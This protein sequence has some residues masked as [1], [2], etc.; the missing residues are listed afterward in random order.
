M[1]KAQ[2]LIASLLYG[3]FC[4]QQAQADINGGGSTFTR[5]LYQTSGVLTAG[6]A[7]YIG[8]DQ[9]RDKVAFLQNNY[10]VLVPGAAP[11][12]VH[13]VASESRLSAVELSNY[14]LAHQAQFGK[15]I[16]VPSA[17]TSVAIPFNK[18]GSHELDLSIDTL[19]GVFS[20]RLSR[21]ELI[22]G[23]ARSGP[24][25]VVYPKGSSGFTELFTR[26][27]NAKCNETGTFAVTTYF[28]SSYS[29]GLPAGAL[30][31]NSGD[32]IMTAVN[33]WDGAITF[34]SPA[35]A[36]PTLAG[37]DDGN[38]VARITGVSP[39]PAN[40]VNAINSVALPP[41]AERSNPDKWVP[42]FGRNWE[43]GVLP[44]PQ[45]GYPILG[46]TNLIFSQCYADATQSNQVRD[47]LAR[48][49]GALEARNNDQAIRA[50]GMLPLH[51]S[52]KVAVRSSFL[53]ATNALSIGN[54]NV[55]NGIGRP[56]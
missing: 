1:P 31:A 47:F 56:L 38:K 53:S 21:W 24:I 44:Y 35:L 5:P 18:P 15:L 10:S 13:W 22:Q 48:H 25:T 14:A 33:V 7:P 30:A 16:Q 20:G 19:C 29:G 36:A 34:M 51:P 50:Q 12:T 4:V 32:A 52:W 54:P 39:A 55:C 3:A 49:Y 27:L 37:L 8:A 42:V 41:I 46:Y 40:I 17:A 45:S 28:D 6:F 11:K 43:Q 26:F 9:G 23:S 2:W